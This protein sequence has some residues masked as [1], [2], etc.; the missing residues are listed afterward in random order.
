MI[1]APVRSRMRSKVLMAALMW[2]GEFSLPPGPHERFLHLCRHILHRFNDTGGNRP[3]ML[4]LTC[5]H[6]LQAKRQTCAFF[7][8]ALVLHD[9]R[10]QFSGLFYKDGSVSRCE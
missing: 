3:A 10:P 6:L 1:V 9:G 8:V 2:S 7:A 5:L 4:V